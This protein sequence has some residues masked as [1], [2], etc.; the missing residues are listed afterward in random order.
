MAGEDILDI[1][2]EDILVKGDSQAAGEGNPDNQ[3]VDV[4]SQDIAPH[5]G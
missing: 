5:M 3:A 4:R 1:A 2:A